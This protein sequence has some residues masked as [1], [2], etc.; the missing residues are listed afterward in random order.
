[1]R[2]VMETGVESHYTAQ[3]NKSVESYKIRRSD[4][5]HFESHAQ[6]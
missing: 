2:L 5:T 1:M 4:A 6:R 3:S